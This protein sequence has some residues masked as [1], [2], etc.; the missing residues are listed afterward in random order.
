[1]RLLLKYRYTCMPENVHKNQNTKQIEKILLYL[2]CA[3]S[4]TAVSSAI[5]L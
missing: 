4:M 5:L 3:W 1:M 2:A